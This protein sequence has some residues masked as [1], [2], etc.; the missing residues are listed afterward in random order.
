MS[1]VEVRTEVAGTI[2]EILV[3]PGQ[4]IAAGESLIIVESMKMELGIETPIG[5]KVSEIKVK[6][7]DQIE[8]GQ[9]VAIVG[10]MFFERVAHFSS[11]KIAILVSLAIWSVIVIYA[12]AYLQTLTEAFIMSGA[13]GFVLGGSQALSR[14]LFSQMIPAGR[15]SSFFGIYEISERGTSWIGPIVFGLVAQLTDSYRPA[16]LAL[17]VF[18]VGGSILLCFVDTGRAIHEAGNLTPEEAAGN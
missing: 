6:K 16:I 18:F 14:S 3:E 4:A 11:S 15:E 1:S 9:V 7:G 5:G 8:E 12:W 10:A 17:V 2:W 13:I